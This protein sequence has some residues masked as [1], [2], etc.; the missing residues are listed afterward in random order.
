MDGVVAV[1]FSG[2]ACDEGVAEGPRLRTEVADI[3]HA[4]ARFLHDFAVYGLIQAFTDFDK[5]RN[6]EKS[7]VRIVDVVRHQELVAVAYCND[8]H[9]RNSRVNDVAAFG[10]N[11]GTFVVAADGYVAAFAAEL[12]QRFP[13]GDVGSGGAAHAFHGI[14]A[15]EGAV[16]HVFI[17]GR[18][19]CFDGR[20][21]IV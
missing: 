5:S 8:D 11:D 18:G 12:V 19:F 16:A 2:K 14:H 10:T 15:A 21:A 13:V 6:Q 20:L 1:E 17:A 7:R 4:E 9:R 3:F